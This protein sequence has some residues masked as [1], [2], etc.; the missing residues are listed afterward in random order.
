[1]IGREDGAAE[2]PIVKDVDFTIAHGE[3]L[4]LIGESGSG[5]TTAW[6]WRCWAMRAGA[7]RSRRGGAG[8]RHG[9]ALARSARRSP[10]SAGAASAYVAQSAAAVVQPGAAHHEPGHRARADPRADVAPRRGGQGARR[11]SARSRCPTRRA[12]AR[13]IPHQVSGGQLQRL[14]AAM[15][16]ITDPELV[17]LDEPTHRARRHH[18]D[19]GA[20]RLQERGPRAGHD[21]A[22]RVAR[23]G[24]GGAD[25]GQRRGAARRRASR[26]RRRSARSSSGAE[27]P[28][29]RSLLAAAAPV[30]DDVPPPLP[31]AAA[32]A[33][34]GVRPCRRLR[35]ARRRRAAAR[36]G[37]ARYR[38]QHRAGL[39]PGR[40]RRSRAAAR[41]RWRRSSPACCRRR[42]A[43]SC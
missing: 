35:R 19:R 11:C 30:R 25:G 39:G 12:S 9:R 13:A 28:Y 31:R 40:D 3:V 21:R 34:A 23:S 8:R 29:T 17:M 41:A 42:A 6:R 2:N 15:A 5:K 33:L 10:I 1:M 26:R 20:A 4:A 36:P 7:A 16:L 43:T 14:M 37:S 38:V 22:L 24:R 32:A 27:H 18:A